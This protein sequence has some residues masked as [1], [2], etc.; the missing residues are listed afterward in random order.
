MK[1]MSPFMG[2]KYSIIKKWAST[3]VGNLQEQMHFCF[4]SVVL[5]ALLLEKKNAVIGIKNEALGL[6]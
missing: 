4:Q 1:V 2:W 6:G 3:G 5:P